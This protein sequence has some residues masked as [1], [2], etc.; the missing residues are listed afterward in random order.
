MVSSIRVTL[1]RP[2]VRTATNENDK[3]TRIDDGLTVFYYP[4]DL[5]QADSL[6]GCPP[7]TSS[8]T[9]GISLS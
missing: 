9:D 5:Y 2:P 3:R 1:P 6:S 7:N 4:N 8:S